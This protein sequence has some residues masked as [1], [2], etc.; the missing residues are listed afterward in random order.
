M[1]LEHPEGIGDR[2]DFSSAVKHRLLLP[3]Q[4]RPQKPIGKSTVHASIQENNRPA[5]LPEAVIQRLY[6]QNELFDAGYFPKP[7]KHR[8]SV[9]AKCQF[10]KDRYLHA[11]SFY[12]KDLR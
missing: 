2:R 1:R 10:H 3:E 9:C 4:I 5:D 7:L 11:I 8:N 6:P 12:F